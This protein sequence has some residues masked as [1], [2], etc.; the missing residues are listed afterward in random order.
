MAPGDDEELTIVMGD[1]D[2]P[3]AGHATDVLK[4]KPV[5]PAASLAMQQY[6]TATQALL[7]RKL[8]E[9]GK[10]FEVSFSK[11]G[12]EDTPGH[13]VTGDVVITAPKDADTEL[14]KKLLAFA[15][16]TKGASVATLN[17]W[18][19]PEAAM[20]QIFKE[21][22]YS[23]DKVFATEASLAKA[24]KTTLLKDEGI[25]VV[26]DGEEW[27]TVVGEDGRPKR[28]HAEGLLQLPRRGMEFVRVSRGENGS[29]IIDDITPGT[30]RTVFTDKDGL[31]NQIK[32]SFSG[33][34]EI[35]IPSSAEAIKTAP[36]VAISA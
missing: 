7:A 1:D 29:V 32:I 36:A 34:L 27:K 28:V 6:I 4:S 12:G 17:R 9:D 35:R 24:V 26:Q 15:K 13:T 3:T 19:V 31:K 11:T 20:R 22:G 18:E 5:Q 23:L 30:S 2:Q 8:G 16:A 10:K 14:T 25:A 33:P 21:E